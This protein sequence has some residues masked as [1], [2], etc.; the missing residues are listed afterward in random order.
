MIVGTELTVEV[1]NNEKRVASHAYS[2]I[3]IALETSYIMG[4]Y[5]K[6]ETNMKTTV[7]PKKRDSKRKNVI[8]VGT[9]IG[10]IVISGMSYVILRQQGSIRTLKMNVKNLTD[11][12]NKTN[13]DVKLLKEV[14]R[15]N[16]I[17]SLRE[18]YKRKLR[19]HE[20][21]LVNGI[22][23]NVMTAKDIE[24]RKEEIEFLSKQ[25]ENIDAAEALMDS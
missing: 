15:G 24:L 16:V 22:A 7:E 10:V 2:F 21:R 19:Y 23:D 9:V 25:L 13:A 1:G 17:H 4:H 5:I 6:E 18:S 14:L 12:Q 11:M 3:F 8:V 20:S